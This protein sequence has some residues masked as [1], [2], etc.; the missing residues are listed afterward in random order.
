M[1]LLAVSRKF[2]DDRRMAYKESLDSSAERVVM[3]YIDMAW[4]GKSPLSL[5][6]YA[7]ELLVDQHQK[8]LGEVVSGL[9]QRCRFAK[10]LPPCTNTFRRQFGLPCAHDPLELYDRGVEVLVDTREIHPFWHLEEHLVCV[11]E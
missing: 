7:I 1:D 3:Q 2:V 5:T 9:P 6:R 4:L 8:M 11:P 10:P